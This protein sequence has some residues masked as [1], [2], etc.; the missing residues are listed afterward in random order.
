LAQV[1]KSRLSTHQ[2]IPWRFFPPEQQNQRPE[3]KTPPRNPGGV[4]FFRLTLQD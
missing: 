2:S 3:T 4:S 1:F